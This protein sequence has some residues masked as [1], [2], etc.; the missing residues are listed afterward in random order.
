A[1]SIAAFAVVK[2][3]GQKPIFSEPMIWMT[4]LAAA[5]FWQSSHIIRFSP[6]W[7]KEIPDSVVNRDGL[8][9]NFVVA[10]LDYENHQSASAVIQDLQSVDADVLLLIELNEP[11]MKELSQIRDSYAHHYEYVRGEGLGIAIWSQ[12]EL[13]EN[14]TKFLIS[15]RRA[16]LWTKLVSP[17]G[18][19]INFVGVHPTPPGLLDSTDDKRRDSRV[20]D[21]E[22]ILVAKL[23]AERTDEPWVVAGDFNDVA[24][25]HTT[26]LFKRTSGLLDPRIGR[27]F[28]GTF[29]AQYPPCRCPID[30][31]LLSK[32][33]AVRQLS[34][35]RI[36]GS[37]HFAVSASVSIESIEKGVEPRPEAN[38]EDDAA[39]IVE[40]G[41]EDAKERGVDSNH[42]SAS[43]VKALSGSQSSKNSETKPNSKTASD[44]EKN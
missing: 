44:P 29:V 4:L 32:D 24:W 13:Q 27:S 41:V 30:H 34:R 36:T 5:F 28:M 10:N 11:W 21:A 14:Q 16:S 22:L 19:A 42:P 9:I 17:Q 38:D 25:S 18:R 8:E 15:N 37:D 31:V 40:E 6:I 3:S 2:T 20:R 1:M 23:I 35:M 33:F 43:K 7:P 26:R 12:L 39:Q